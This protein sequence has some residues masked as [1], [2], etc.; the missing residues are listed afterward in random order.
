[1]LKGE[2]YVFE[3]VSPTSNRKAKVGLTPYADWVRHKD[4]KV[5]IRGIKVTAAQLKK[6]QT[7]A[8]R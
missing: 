5:W 7:V 2:P 3:A 4:N 8:S 6:M 1:M